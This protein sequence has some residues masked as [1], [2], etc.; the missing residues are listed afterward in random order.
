MRSRAL[1]GNV[2][3]IT[4]YSGL[5]IGIAI[6]ANWWWPFA[7][8]VGVTFFGYLFGLSNYGCDSD[9]E[10]AEAPHEARSPVSH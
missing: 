1:A 7:V 6:R 3:T 4:A 10:G 5:I 2:A 8:I 9:P